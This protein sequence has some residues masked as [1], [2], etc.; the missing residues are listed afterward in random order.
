MT[1]KRTF[2]A[3]VAFALAILL[4]V[5]LSFTAFATSGPVYTQTV[6]E[7][8]TSK[9]FND[10]VSYPDESLSA[11]SYDDA[12]NAQW[13]YNAEED[14]I[15]TTAN[16]GWTGFYNPEI[17]NFTTGE[18]TFNMRNENFDPSG[19]TWGMVKSGTDEDPIYS[20]YVYEECEDSENWCVA[21]VENWQPAKS[22][23]S[24]QGPVYHSTIDADDY[25]YS[26]SGDAGNVG[27][28]TGTI[29]AYG[30]LPGE[31]YKTTHKVAINVEDSGFSVMVNDALLTTVTAS[32]Q[33]GS[34]G[35]Y[36]CSNPDAYFSNLSFTSSDVNMINAEFV[37]TD[38][39]GN[40]VTETALNSEINVVDKSTYE[41]SPIA[42]RLWIVSKDGEQVYSGSTPYADYTKSAGK[43]VT[44]LQVVSEQGVRSN[45]CTVELTVTDTPAQPPQQGATSSVSTED[46]AT[47][48]TTVVSNNTIATS[49]TSTAVIVLAVA[50]GAVV[51]AIAVQKK[52]TEN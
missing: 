25:D 7:V 43:Y 13:K 36:A 11:S 41:G 46:T 35:P 29:L 12:Y 51:V 23:Y 49:E 45:I 26:H 28:A 16:V 30:E 14:Y 6:I 34:F 24:H 21:Y 44:T 3:V 48:A 32:V 38:K 37:Y 33:K 50:I 47:Q 19:F 10:W 39:D 8:D 4:T 5:A 20:F 17:T 31:C 22:P 42:N 1:T 9:I 40:V 27:F 18:F 2:K 52:R 15:N